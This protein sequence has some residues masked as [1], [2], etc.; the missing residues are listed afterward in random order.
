MMKKNIKKFFK[1]VLSHNQ[2]FALSFL[3]F[4]I[5]GGGDS[6]MYLVNS[7]VKKRGRFLDIGSNIGIYTYFFSNKFS[8]VD[9]F[10]PLTEITNRIKKLNK[11]NIEI[12]NV[13]LSNCNSQLTFYIPIIDGKSVTSRASLELQEIPFEERKVEV[14]TLDSYEFNN[15]DLIKIDVEG[16]EYSVLEGSLLTIKRCKPILLIEIE[17]RH[18]SRPIDDVFNLILAQ[19]YRGFFLFEKSLVS[20]SEFKYERHQLSSIEDPS[21]DSYVNNFI[22]IPKNKLD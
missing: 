20:L 2:Y 10:E 13:A 17:Q 18:I 19:E 8:Y 6:E 22:F 4:R 15:V 11:Q 21:S 3:W 1:S 14:K 7:L 12:H 16:H 5:K 9:S